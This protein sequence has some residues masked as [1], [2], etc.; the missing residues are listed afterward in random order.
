MFRIA[1]YFFPL[2]LALA[3]FTPVEELKAENEEG[4]I[5]M[6]MFSERVEGLEGTLKSISL[7]AADPNKIHVWIVTDNTTAINI[8]ANYMKDSGLKI[9]TMEIEAVVKQLLDDGQKPV[10]TWKQYGSS[11]NSKAE[12]NRNWINKNSARPADWDHSP[13]HMHQL[14][15]LRFYIPYMEQ[16]KDIDRVIFLDDDLIVQGDVKHAWDTLD[17]LPE[18]KM[19]VG[20]C[21]IWRYNPDQQTF[22]LAGGSTY[23]LTHALGQGGRTIEETYCN[24]DTQ[25]DCVG[26][27]H[28]K[29]LQQ[30]FLEI[31][32]QP[33]DFDNQVE[34]NYGFALFDLK[35]WRDMELTATYEQWMHA[36]YDDHIFPESSLMYGLG[37]AF[38]A[39]YDRVSCWKDVAQPSFNVRDGL[40]YM[41]YPELKFNGLDASFITSA[42]VLHYDGWQK[43]WLEEADEFFSIPYQ[44][45]MKGVKAVDYKEMIEDPKTYEALVK[46]PRQPFLIITDKDGKSDWFLNELADDPRICVSTRGG[47]NRIGFPSDMFASNLKKLETK[48]RMRNQ[49]YFSFIEQNLPRV[50]ENK[51]KYCQNDKLRYGQFFKLSLD[52]EDQGLQY[53]LPMLCEWANRYPQGYNKS[54]LFADYVRSFYN[55]EASWACQCSPT[56]QAKGAFVRT[57]WMD[58]ASLNLLWDSVQEIKPKVIFFKQYAQHWGPN[59]HSGTTMSAVKFQASV[60]EILKSKNVDVLEFESGQCFGKESRCVHKI[61]K[62]IGL[63]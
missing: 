13:M 33:Y 39:F 9:H 36:N 51:E 11:V 17:N 42:H 35:K 5:H 40:G 50:I 37:I 18:E 54:S 38:L 30:R 21:E 57:A 44:Q 6:C 3:A 12:F 8:V 29:N 23:A 25:V 60:V 32:G 2:A 28:W 58:E 1:K 27:N 63:D 20:A 7:N 26:S 41:S 59:M 22:G 45:T 48:Q 15:H 47:M 61:T 43:P 55:G 16:F 4:V 52:K 24:D 56:T 34:W 19:M 53:Q 10:W 31:N 62:F 14:N 46:K 49:C